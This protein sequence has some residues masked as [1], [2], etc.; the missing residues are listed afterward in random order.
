MSFES[1]QRAWES[2]PHYREEQSDETLPVKCG[3][4]ECGAY[5]VE[6][7]A[8]V[9]VEWADEH[10]VVYYTCPACESET[11]SETTRERYEYEPEVE[12]FDWHHDR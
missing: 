6:V 9:Y 1:A 10:G 3:T 5:D 2:P 4:E 11:E 12:D 8:T 7:N